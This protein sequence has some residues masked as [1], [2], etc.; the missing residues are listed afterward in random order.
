MKEEK[1]S[2]RKKGSHRKSFFCA[3]PQLYTH[4]NI[5]W[6]FTTDKL[7]IGRVSLHIGQRH[8]GVAAITIMAR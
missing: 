2:E 1:E 5:N 6:M 8:P 7:E 3:A 4:S